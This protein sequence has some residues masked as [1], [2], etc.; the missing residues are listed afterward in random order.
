MRIKA[1]SFSGLRLVLLVTVVLGMNPLPA[2][3]AGIWDTISGLWQR[4]CAPSARLDPEYVFQPRK[5]WGAGAGYELRSNSMELCPSIE[6]TGSASPSSRSVNLRVG[7]RMAHLALIQATYGP[8]TLGLSQEVGAAFTKNRYNFLGFTST[9]FAVDVRYS[10]Y[11]DIPECTL[12]TPAGASV[13][14]T[15]NAPAQV[16]DL[17]LSGVYAFGKRFTYQAVYNGRSVQRRSGGSW[18]AAAR[19]MRGRIILDPQDAALMGNLGGYGRYVTNQV[20]LGGGYSF[21]WVL[22][23]RDAPSTTDLR[24]LRNLVFNVT[25]TPLL[26]LY[27]G[28]TYQQYQQVKGYDYG[29]PEYSDQI[30]NT[31]RSA[32]RILPNFMTRAG[33]VYHF[34]HFYVSAWGEYTRFELSSKERRI[35]NSTT[36]SFFSQKGSFSSWSVNV[37]LNYGF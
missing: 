4:L 21:N 15:V 11:S 27:N 25:A 31:Y 22:Y 20:S 32:G 26:T 30:V 6:Y 28:V 8:L 35:D 29:F 37:K 16:R 17:V 13:P 24:G 3:A 1:L 34:G 7:P 9:S 19:Y 33:F 18:L 23:H 10:S 2:S 12:S 5:G 14:L 36:T